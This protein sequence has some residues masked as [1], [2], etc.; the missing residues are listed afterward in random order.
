MSSKFSKLQILRRI[1]QIVFFALL[2]TLFFKL[3][4]LNFMKVLLVFMIIGGVWYCG[5]ICPFG[6]LQEIINNIRFKIFKKKLIIP[7]KLHLI[8]V[9]LRY[10]FF[11]LIVFVG[12]S[13]LTNFDARLWFTIFLNG[14]EIKIISIVSIVLFL[15]LSLFI[16][17][18]FCNYFCP[19]GARYGLWSLLRVFTFKRNKEKCIDCGKCDDACP[20]HIN[21][22]NKD[23]VRSLQCINCFNCTSVCP[24]EG[25]LKYG[26]F[27]A[28]GYLGIVL[29]KFK[30]L[31]K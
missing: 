22:S 15:L 4:F 1:F 6:A 27:D 26:F 24:K 16:D 23:D 5:W 12:I 21:I 2:F 25:A 29:N 31:F 17:R 14:A 28:K 8:L 3:N 20:M 30:K 19:D 7:R 9:F 11:V 13:Y 10:V 18:P